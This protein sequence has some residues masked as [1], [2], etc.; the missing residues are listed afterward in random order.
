MMEEVLTRAEAAALHFIRHG[1][2]DAM[3][4]YN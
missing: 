2:I 1:I 4:R 3:N